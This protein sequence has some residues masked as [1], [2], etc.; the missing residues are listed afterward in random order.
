MRRLL[1]LFVILLLSFGCIEEKGF[2]ST[3]NEQLLSKEEVDLDSNG[4][5]DY[6]VYDYVPVTISGAG[7][8]VQRQVTVATQT[9]ATYTTINP[10]LTDVDLLI[11]DQQLDEFSKSRIQAD[12]ACSNNIGL[13][14]VACSDVTT[15]AKLC[16]GASVKC[17]KIAATH[18]EVLADSMVSYVQSNNEIRSLILDARRMVLNLRDATDEERDAFLGKIAGMIGGVAAINSNPLYTHPDVLLCSHSDFGVDYLLD[19][20]STIGNYSTAPSSYHY[21]VLLSVK[22]IQQTAS[23]GVGV[24][25]GGVGLSDSIPKTAVP[26]G[27]QISSVQDLTVSE[28]GADVGVGWE[29]G[30]PSKEGYLLSYEFISTEAPESFLPSLKV[31]T[32]TIRT[33]NLSWLAP[34]NMLLL[35]VHGILENYFLALGIALGLTLSVLLFA[36]NMVILV[37][38]M[39]REKAVGGTFTAGFRKAFGRTDVRWKGDIIVAV[40]LLA[41]GFYLTTFVATQPSVF[42]PLLE[43]VDVL[44][45]DNWGTF[46]LGLA[47]IGVVMAYM[48]VENLAKITILERAYGMVIRQEKDM[49]LARAATLKEKIKELKGIVDEYSKEE[50]DVSKEYDVLTSMRSETVDKLAKTMTAQSKTLIDEQLTRVEN[51]IS[52]LRERKKL[53]DENWP[54]WKDMITKL[55][56]EQ[57][58]VYISSLGTI[59]ASLRAWAFGRYAKDVGPENITFERDSL[60]K[61]KM[62]VRDLVQDM[63][64]RGLIKGAVVLKQKKIEAAE[65]TDGGNTVMKILSM[66]L[67]SY[68]FSLAKE[69]GQSQPKSFAAVGERNVLLLMKGRTIESMIA[70]PKDKFKEAVEYWKARTKIL[71]TR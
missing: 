57:E 38:S 54:K 27:E 11:A 39:V 32:V 21:T 20:A 68:L 44:L 61:R 51:S 6:L 69:L 23:E 37:F 8:K 40:L 62:T 29:S 41:L 34:I 31:P 19:A 55:L 58:E 67:R 50:F 33:I 52:S 47:L 42:P 5:N 10:D 26:N 45:A 9:T 7:V 53:A 24:E 25:V 2:P 12:T 28:N 66:K 30:K 63:M 48:A 35:T 16:S 15:C 59:P 65:F 14:G 1:L 3:K 36:Y 4:I 49:F 43:I 17:K 60:K 13:L 56:D 64:D 70:V 46:G 22:P 18:E 71:E